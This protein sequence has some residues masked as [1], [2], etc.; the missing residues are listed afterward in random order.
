MSHPEIEL[1]A[2]AQTIGVELD[3]WEGN[4]P[5]LAVEYRNDL[6]GNP[7]MFHGGAVAGLLEMAAVA[8]LD[9]DLREKQGLSRLTPINS[10]VE[11][12]RVAGEARTFAS[13]QIVRAGRRLA[14]VQAT[15]WQESREKPVATSIVNI[16]IA[17][18]EG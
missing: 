16:A 4:K 10:T 12:L 5:I 7:G 11:F 3:S 18:V 14:N 9:A 1:P 8:T 13:A 15:L 6:C 17:P 2:Y